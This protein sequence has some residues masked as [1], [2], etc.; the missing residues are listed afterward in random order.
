MTKRR[1]FCGSAEHGIHRRSFLGRAA[2]LGGAT[3]QGLELLKQP[4]VAE[5]LKQNEKR[6]ILL[7]LAGGA[8]Q[9]ETWDPK[10]GRPTGGPFAAIRTSE[11]GLQISELMPKMAQRMRH[12]AVLRSL[13]TRDGNHGTA[14]RLMHLGRRDEPN[15]K[16]PDLGAVCARELT[17]ADAQVPEYVAFYTATEGRANAVGQSGFLGARY[18]PMFLT[19][20][21]KP[22]NLDREAGLSELDH[23]ARADLRAL[24]RPPVRC[25]SHFLNTRQSQ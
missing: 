2:L 19:T 7:W 15:V 5:T 25:R 10:P 13:N 17:K 3:M 11:P 4:A 6:V 12:T 18:M 9:L 8:S 14:A 1:T 16:Y 21:T 24:L 22:E 23:R 20:N